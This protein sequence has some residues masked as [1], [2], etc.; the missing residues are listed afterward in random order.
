MDYKT[1]KSKMPLLSHLQ[2]ENKQQINQLIHLAG[3]INHLSERVTELQELDTKL[4]AMVEVSMDDQDLQS[5]GMGGPITS[6]TPPDISKYKNHHEMVRSMHLSISKLQEKIDIRKKE[7]IKLHNIIHNEKLRLASTPSIW[8]TRGWVSSGFGTRLSPFTGRKEV[9]NGIDI[10]ARMNT[11]VI[12][13][14]DGTVSSTRRDN[15]SGNVIYINH[16][17]GIVTAYAHLEKILVE[18]G[19]FVKRGEVIGLVGNTGRSTGPHLHY[20]VN[21]NGVPTNPYNYI[22]DENKPLKYAGRK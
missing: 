9:H 16:G 12:A 1:V 10:S 20:E 2:E 17:Y 21:V 18:K 6:E 3:Y 4:K 13:P 8:P 7:K 22:L 11:P 14:A 19:R 5:P 15:W